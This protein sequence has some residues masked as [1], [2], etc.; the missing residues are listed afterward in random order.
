MLVS[1]EVLFEASLRIP[2]SVGQAITIVGTIVIGQSAVTAKLVSPV[3]VVVLAITSTASFVMPNQDFSNA[4]RLWRFLLTV[5]G[6]LAGLFGL[7]VGMIIL[8]WHLSKLETFGVPY[9][10]PLVSGEGVKQAEDTFIRLPLKFNKVRP[11]NLK[12]RNRKREYPGLPGLFHTQQGKQALRKN[13]RCYRL[14]RQQVIRLGNTANDLIADVLDGLFKESEHLSTTR[15]VKT[16]EVITKFDYGLSDVYV[17]AI[18]L[19]PETGAGNESS[20]TP[21]VLDGFAVFKGTSLA[22][23]IPGS[24]ARGVNWVAGEVRSCMLEVKDSSG[25]EVMLE[26]VVSDSKITADFKNDVPDEVTIM[27]SLKSYI[28]EQQ[29]QINIF[30]NLEID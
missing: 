5:M 16:R 2:R 8:L 6:S 29:S 21:I 26:T 22:G 30:S 17:P 13:G 11:A 28:T 3:V 9:L 10:S 15:P 14:R 4:I 7:V 24:A 12:V 18:H 23:S 19:L 27:V 20:K 25:Q 1:F